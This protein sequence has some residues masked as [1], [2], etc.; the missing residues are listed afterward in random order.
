M[1]YCFLALDGITLCFG[2]IIV[3]A[4]FY[5]MH[6]MVETIFHLEKLNKFLKG[7]VKVSQVGAAGFQVR[8]RA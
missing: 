4:M 2:V 6:M 1:D 5:D 7:L 3:A 8:M